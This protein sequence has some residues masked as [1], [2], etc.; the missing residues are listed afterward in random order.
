MSLR[1][2]CYAIAFM[3]ACIEPLGGVGYT[4]LVQDAVNKLFVEYLRVFSAGKIAVSL[5]P[6]APAVGHTVG[7]LFYGSFPA[8]RAVRLRNA[9]F[10]KIFLCKNV[11]GD[12]APLF[13]H[14]YI[15]HFK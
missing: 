11:G 7:Y 12:L 5:T 1:L 8:Q 2:A 9:C 13:W 4:S 14:F 10:T 15:V 3:Q 6:Y